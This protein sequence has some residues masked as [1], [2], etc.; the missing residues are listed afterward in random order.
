[1][2]SAN[3]YSSPGTSGGNRE[4]LTDILTIIAPEATPVKSAIRSGPGP[5][6]TYT[7]VVVD[8][9]R[10][11][12][13]TGQPEGYDQGQFSN[14]AKDRARLGNYIHILS[15]GYAVT[16]VENMVAVAGAKGGLY[17][18]ARAK[19]LVELSRDIEAVICG[20]QDRNA[21]GSNTPDG[22]WTTRGLF[23]WITSSG[24][25]S[26]IPSAY[27]TPSGNV[28]SFT[29]ETSITG[30]LNS[31][32]AQYGEPKN[33][34]VPCGLATVEKFDELARTVQIGTG[35]DGSFNRVTNQEYI[36]GRTAQ[37]SVTRYVTSAGSMDIVPDMFVNVT[38]GTDNTTSSTS[39]LILNMDLVALQTMEGLHS[40]ELVDEGG[41][42]RGFAKIVFA[43]MCKNPRGL[44]KIS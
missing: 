44:G 26:D 33:Y 18:E 20:N 3:S 16:D 28:I 38:S 41:G 43:V 7:E 1:M 39:G 42:P 29:S 5:K 17:Q 15:E 9:L 14:K 40:V 11:A 34:F 13:T 37:R 30:A 27:V 2:P 31:L 32:F 4:D 8:T 21:P 36:Q 10:S 19:A 24:A 25:P 12:R 35:S 23:K 6:A 22:T